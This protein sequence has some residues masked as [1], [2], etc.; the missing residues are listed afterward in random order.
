MSL[1]FSPITFRDIEIRNRLWVAPMCQYSAEDGVVNAWHMQWL[2][3]LATGGH[4]LVMTE[5]TA[6][7]PVGRHSL[8]DAGLWRDD[9]VDAW[10]PI[11]SFCRSYGATMAVQLAHAGRKAGTQ[12]PWTGR[13]EL[14]PEQGG[15][16]SVG[17]SPIP[18][19][20]HTPPRA[21][22][23]PE[24]KGVVEDFVSAARRAVRAGFQVIEIHSAH[25]YLLH[26]FLSPL[27]NERTDEYG[28]SFE[29]RTRLTL[30]VLRAVRA[31]VGQGMPIF[32]RLS[33]TDYT[34]GGWT[35]D[36]TVRLSSML[37]DA[38][39]DLV[40]CSSGGL[41]PVNV[42]EMEVGPGYQ[43]PF[44][45]AVRREAHV[46]SGA[47]GLITDAEQAEAILQEGHADVVL[48]ARAA[49]RDPHFAMTSAEQLGEVIPWP[50]QLER[51]RRVR[52][53]R[54]A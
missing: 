6:V 47:V 20:G 5:A 44:A 49:M 9:H 53:R 22:T 26:E 7:H 42:T 51:A 2:G 46:P 25:G 54:Q 19:D 16:E 12:P 13:A 45:S 52:R 18:A 14:T 8:L 37:K 11:V 31:E 43:V 41:V 40:D 1:L 17:P 3:S 50:P 32:V 33:S 34:V 29:N 36:D 28:G 23:I 27:S 4:G 39:C 48:V 30:E 24:I 10:A 35:I 15:W 21:L 38:G